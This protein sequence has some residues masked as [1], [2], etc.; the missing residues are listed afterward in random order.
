M[1]KEKA[2]IAHLQ[3]TH[4][5]DKEHEKLRK[6]GFTKTFFSSYKSNHKR[7]VAIL[8]SNKVAFEQTYEQMDKEGRF[9]F[10]GKIDGTELTLLNIY[11]PPGSAFSFSQDDKA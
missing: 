8:I 7:G 6:M 9:L 4:L 11:A 5:N 3:E 10:R 1:K 2:H